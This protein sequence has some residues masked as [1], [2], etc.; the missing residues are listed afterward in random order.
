MQRTTLLALS[1][2]ALTALCSAQTASFT[3]T[4]LAPLVFQFTDTST[5][6]TPTAWAWDFDGDG[7]PDDTN[8]N[9][10]WVF[11]E[12]GGYPVTLTVTFASSTAT[13]TQEV[14]PNAITLPPFGST[15][16]SGALTRGYW[17]Q[18][19]ERF[20]IISLQVPDESAHGTQNVAVYRM[21]SPPPVFSA[22]ATGGLE[23]FEAG[24]PSNV[25][26]PCVVSYDVGEYV[27]VLGACG[28]ATTMR[29]SYCN[30]TQ[31]QPGELLG[32]PIQLSRFLTQTN[33]VTNNGMGAYSTE[34][35]G[36]VTRIYTEVTPCVGI[37]YGDGS[38]SSQAPAP[39]LSTTALPFLG[40]TA[41]LTVEN[42]DTAAL[43]I[44]AVGIGRANV[45]SPLGTVLIGSID[46]SVALNNG[47]LMNPGSYTF[48]WAI[49]NNPAL[50]GF[51]PVN[52]QAASLVTGTGEFALSNGNEWWLSAQ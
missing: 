2:S 24:T 21:S 27:G 42:S 13:T 41:E 10:V 47:A 34:V 18:T 4:E 16:S 25:K 46:G 51:G 5:G 29:N 17:F 38:P 37:P 50:Q 26:I 9:P 12:G 32:V 3:A 30:A 44:V 11:Q 39:V 23:F 43:G 14:F 8:Q 6:G 1:S 49:P 52:W 19:P 22:N 15:F 35:N 36:Y 20:S 45:P 31:A 28:D 33:I 7:N 48:Q 40:Q